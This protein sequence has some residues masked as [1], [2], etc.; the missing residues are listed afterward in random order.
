MGLKK[1]HLIFIHMPITLSNTNGTGNFTLVNNTNSGGFAASIAAVATGSIV[2]SGLV[3]NL[4]ASNASSYPGSGTTWTDLSST[5][6]NGTLVGDF[7]YFLSH[8]TTVPGKS[9][10][11][12]DV[13]TTLYGIPQEKFVD[14]FADQTEPTVR[15]DQLMK[16]LNLIVRFLGS[17]VHPVAG[18]PP[19]PVA[20]DGTDIQTI[21]TKLFDADNSILNQ[22]IRIN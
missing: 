21:F 4:D 13:K 1:P 10:V 12:L 20:T 15:G 22:N 16:L 11:N 19:V 7:I 17:H 14:E 6:N 18:T 3:L 2:T 5:A 8:K 9:K